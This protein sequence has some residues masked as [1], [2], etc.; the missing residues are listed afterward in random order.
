MNRFLARG[1]MLTAVLLSL[2]ACSA[3]AQANPGEVKHR[4]DCRLAEQVLTHGQPANKRDWALGLIGTCDEAPA[5]LPGL[6]S[7]QPTAD[8]EIEAL[9]HASIRSGDEAT[10]A[11]ALAAAQDPSAI[12]RLRLAGLATVVTRVRSDL[13]L[14]YDHLRTVSGVPPLEW[15]NMWSVVDHPMGPETP[16]PSGADAQVAALVQTLITDSDTM[17]RDA[18]WWL[19]Q[20]HG[21]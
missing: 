8:S 11:A 1:G 15:D 7:Q 20:L 17:V 10:F 4:N 12:S 3:S 18:A 9:Y 6:W 2:V 19:T 14:S 13:F 21:F 5:V 16:P